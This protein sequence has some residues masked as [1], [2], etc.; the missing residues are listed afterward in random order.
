M[1]YVNGTSDVYCVHVYR[2]F[3][4]RQSN[5]HNSPWYVLY[6]RRPLRY[7]KIFSQFRNFNVVNNG[8]E[9]DLGWTPRIILIGLSV[10]W[11]WALY[12]FYTQTHKLDYNISCKDIW[13]SN[14]NISDSLWSAFLG[15]IITPI[16]RATFPH[17]NDIW[18][19]Q[20]NLLSLTTLRNFY[21]CT[22][23]IASPSV[24]GEIHWLH[25]SWETHEMSSLYSMMIHWL[26]ELAL[27][28][29]TM[30]TKSLLTPS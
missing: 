2:Y 15:L 9:G 1:A 12:L 19:F 29:S 17:T 14:A 11:V 30:M 24:R 27:S 7:L 25:F 18:S 8:S 26:W 10:K 4:K 16:P 23:A 13:M 3:V 21:L 6:I 28:H 5:T 20:L 22:S